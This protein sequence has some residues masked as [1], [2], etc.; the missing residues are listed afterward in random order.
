MRGLRRARVLRRVPER[1]LSPRRHYGFERRR[2]ET[3]RQTRQEAKRERRAGREAQGTAGP[4]MG[5]PQDGAGAPAGRWEWFSP[6]RGRVV[7][8]EPKRRPPADA[9]DDWTL[10][11]DGAA[12]TDV[13]PPPS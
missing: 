4:E 7:T 12:V 3:Q 11:T 8:T 13:D 6:S 2:R 9:P 5:Q 10:L 1:C